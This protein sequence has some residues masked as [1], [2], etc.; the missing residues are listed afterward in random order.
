MPQY[1][2]VCESCTKDWQEFHSINEKVN[3]CPFCE[4]ENFVKRI[5][6]PVMT[7]IKK[8]SE[9]QT[10]ELVKQYIEENKQVL[11]DYQKELKS[12]KK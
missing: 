12:I 4:L 1:Y 3:I 8:Q 11:K 2:Y 7:A 10:G 9:K 6:S 5:P